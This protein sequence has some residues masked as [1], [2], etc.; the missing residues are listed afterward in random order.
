MR[1][2]WEELL[3][4]RALRVLTDWLLLLLGLMRVCNEQA[5]LEPKRVERALRR[6]IPIPIRLRHARISHPRRTDIHSLRT[7]HFKPHPTRPAHPVHPFHPLHPA[8]I[9]TL[10]ILVLIILIVLPIQVSLPIKVQIQV[11]IR[12]DIRAVLELVRCCCERARIRVRRIRGKRWVV[13]SRGGGG[14]RSVA[15]R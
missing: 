11:R 2:E 4:L 1:W 10:I 8:H 15:G 14:W 3:L 12:V 5:V 7:R 13:R 9:S 6:H